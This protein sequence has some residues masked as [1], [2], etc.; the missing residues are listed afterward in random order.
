MPSVA[1]RLLKQS[2]ALPL[3][4][5]PKLQGPIPGDAGFFKIYLFIYLIF[6]KFFIERELSAVSDC[7]TSAP[8]K[9]I[10]VYGGVGGTPSYT[11][12]GQPNGQQG[13][14]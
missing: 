13:G 3:M 1:P 9:I 14:V 10:M 12:H 7:N 5:G 4:F 6:L 8:M 2:L 11:S